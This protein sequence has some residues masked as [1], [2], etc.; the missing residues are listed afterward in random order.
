MTFVDS[1]DAILMLYSYS[2]FPDRS[3]AIFEEAIIPEDGVISQVQ[4]DVSQ[5]RHHVQGVFPPALEEGIIQETSRTEQDPTDGPEERN[6]RKNSGLQ[7]QYLARDLRVK[8]NTMSGL[9]ITL[10]L[11]SILVAFRFV[12]FL[13]PGNYRIL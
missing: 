7:T 3:W 10:T 1:V 8:R 13:L 4:G 2:G 5:Q 11:M 9:S 6:V 12:I